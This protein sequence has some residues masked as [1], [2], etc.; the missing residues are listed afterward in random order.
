M[1]SNASSDALG[2]PVRGMPKTVREKNI[3]FNVIKYFEDEKERH[4][5][6]KFRPNAVMQKAA[7]ATGVPL[8]TLQRLSNANSESKKIECKKA[9]LSREKFG[10]LD[11]FDLGVIRRL[12]HQFYLRNESPTLD[13]ILKEL[14]EKM[15]FLYGRSHL[16]K[17]LKKMGFSFKFRGKERLIYER[18]DIIAWRE[19]YLRAIKKFR[20]NNPDKDIVYTDET[21]LNQGHRTKKEWVDVESLKNLSRRQPGYND[22]TIGCTKPSTGKGGRLIISDA[23]T[24]K[25]PVDG[26]L[27]IFKAAQGKKPNKKVKKPSKDCNREKEKE[28]AKQENEE[29][30]MDE[31][32]S[33]EG[34]LWQEDYHD[35]MNGDSYEQYF[36][37]SLCTNVPQGSLIVID[38]AP[39]HSRNDET[40]PVSKWKK[41]QYIDWLKSMDIA[42]PKKILRAELWTMCKQ[43]R[44]RYPAK[45]VESI[46]KNAGHET[47]PLPP[48]HCELNPIEMVWGGP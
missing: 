2:F 42:V 41:Q 14:K 12:I 31:S 35:S 17:L 1:A 45:I 3:I 8:R 9:K 21:W 47:L 26:S 27:W 18:S 48:H 5:K 44:D 30:K 7:E 33:S 37:N 29:E 10:K 24:N 38:N 34:I 32:N 4:G 16:H 43:E 36:A 25:G 20:E 46:A 23:M 13:K 11:E 15:D 19:C 40:Y 28:C 39:Y 6:Q 22:L